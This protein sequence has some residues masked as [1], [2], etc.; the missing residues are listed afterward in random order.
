MVTIRATMPNADQVLWPGTLVNTQLTLRVTEG[1]TV[2]ATALQLS[3]SGT[4]V[5]VVKDDVVLVRPVKVERTVDGESVIA[6][7]LTEG[8]V[9]VTDGQLLLSNGTR[10]TQRKRVSS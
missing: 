4:F 10:V 9:V 6:S 3:Q 5:F 7:G 2:P 1:V 8:E